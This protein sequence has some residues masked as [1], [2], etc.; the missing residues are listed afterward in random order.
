MERY[1]IGISSVKTEMVF[2]GDSSEEKSEP[3][4]DEIMISADTS[5]PC[6]TPEPVSF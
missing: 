5:S 4:V 3:M 1:S 6:G 2:A